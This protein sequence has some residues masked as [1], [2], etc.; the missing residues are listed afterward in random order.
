MSTVRG[1]GET[2]A[3]RTTL[4][5]Q[6]TGFGVLVVAGLITR[7]AAVSD[8][9]LL[10]VPATVVALAALW[11]LGGLTRRRQRSAQAAADAGGAGVDRAGVRAGTALV[12]LTAVAA[13]VAE[14]LLRR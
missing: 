3:P 14:V 13:L 2:Q 8:D 6:R 12:V 11:V 7:A 5:W 1:S 4:A 9:P 10:L